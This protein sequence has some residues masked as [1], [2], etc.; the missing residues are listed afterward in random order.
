MANKFLLCAAFYLLVIT[1][2]VFAM[3]DDGDKE[4]KEEKV[5]LQ[6]RPPKYGLR[7]NETFLKRGHYFS[8]ENSSSRDPVM[9]LYCGKAFKCSFKCREHVNYVHKVKYELP[10]SEQNLNL[11]K[12]TTVCAYPMCNFKSEDKKAFLEHVSGRKKEFDKNC[13]NKKMVS[14]L[15]NQE[16]I[17]NKKRKESVFC[18]QAYV[19]NR[20]LGLR[21]IIKDQKNEYRCGTCGQ[22]LF[23]FGKSVCSNILP[24][25]IACNNQCTKPLFDF[26]NRR[27]AREGEKVEG[28]SEKLFFEE[29]K[30][31]L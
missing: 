5:L 1:N 12:I 23:F 21:E 8:A 26:A 19:L 18:K 10:F 27:R 28:E 30:I 3:C 16:N 25:L 29:K 17:V 4:N 15:K 2:Y 9:C 7:A 20:L 22:R 13:L 31:K 11:I 24:H 14:G 6:V